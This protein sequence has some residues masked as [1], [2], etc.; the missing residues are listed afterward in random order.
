MLPFRQI[1]VV[2]SQA[3][4]TCKELSTCGYRQRHRSLA[5]RPAA[6]YSWTSVRRGRGEIA[7]TRGIGELTAADQYGQACAAGCVERLDAGRFGGGEV[8][9]G[10]EQIGLGERCDHDQQ[11]LEIGQHRLGAAARIAAVQSGA[12]RQH[13]QD[14]YLRVAL[15]QTATHRVAA[16]D[17]KRTTERPARQLPSVREAQAHLAAEGADHASIERCYTHCSPIIA[18]DYHPRLSPTASRACTAPTI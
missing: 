4:M 5:C 17:R 12:P 2:E 13:F 3:L 6:R 10:D 16:D 9:V 14:V 7:H 11:P 8:A 18:R 15:I 1:K